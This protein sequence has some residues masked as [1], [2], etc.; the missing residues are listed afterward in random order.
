MMK[1]LLCGAT[2]AVSYASI[3]LADGAVGYWPL[4]D[5]TGTTAEDGT[6][7]NRDGTYTGGYTLADGPLVGSLGNVVALDG[8][9]DY[10]SIAD[11]DAWSSSAGGSGQITVE[12]WIRPSAVNRA[13][14]MIVAKHQEWQLRIES[15]GKVLWDVNSVGVQE[16]MAAT[17]SGALTANTVYHVVGTYN[18]ATPRLDLWIDGVSVASD[19][20]VQAASSSN[21]TNA[22]RIGGRSDNAGNEF[23]GRIGH[24]AIYPTA[25]TS[26]QIAAHNTAGRA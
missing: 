8:T 25:L 19:T 13:A 16:V 24:V 4:T 6:T 17:S 20:S 22:L 11:A 14:T 18:R 12:A 3:V 23:L 26:T 5:T 21:T 7:N 1:A 10:I 9:D 2:P 15:D